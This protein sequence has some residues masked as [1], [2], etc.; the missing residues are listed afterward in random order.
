MYADGEMV[1][2][3]DVDQDLQRHDPPHTKEEWPYSYDPFST[4][5]GPSDHCN[6]SVYTDRMSDWAHDKFKELGQK[7]FGTGPWFNT[8]CSPQ[9]VEQFLREYTGNDRITLTRVVEYCNVATGYPTWRLDY[10]DPE[11]KRV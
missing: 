7:I 8:G 5:G 2:D 9:K 11:L 1:L 4:W 6:G 10:H 3:F